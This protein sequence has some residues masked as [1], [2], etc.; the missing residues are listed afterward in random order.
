[1][2]PASELANVGNNP[3]SGGRLLLAIESSCDDTSA[4]VL[5]GNVVLSNIVAGQHI[6]ARYGGV[7]PELASRAHQENI[8]PVVDTAISEANVSTSDIEAI[9]F[10]QGPG[11]MGSLLVG[12]SF[13]KAMALSLD[14]PLVAVDHMQAHILAHLIYDAERSPPLFPFLCLTVSGGHTQLVLVHSALEFELM[15]QTLDDA[16]GEAFDKAAKMLG[17]GYPGGPLVD[18]LAKDGDPTRFVFA[19]PQVPGLDMSFSGMKSSLLQLIHKESKSDARFVDENLAHLCAS[20][21]NAVVAYLM[22]KTEAAM[23][24]TNARHLAVAGGVSANSLLRSELEGLANR[25][26]WSA[27]IPRFEYCTDNAAMIGMAGQL[28]LDAGKGADQLTV[29]K[30]RMPW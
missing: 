3:A 6:H 19:R 5:R 30:A 23:S 14:V 17:L 27:H 1:M 18:R 9:A 25:H 24:L 28:L 26:G 15:G 10:T 21:Q 11:L 22:K 12:A 29:P 16:A 4:S 2:K 20:F 13:A 7:V 8:V